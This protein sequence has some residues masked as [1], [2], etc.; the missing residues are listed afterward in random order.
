MKKSGLILA[1]ICLMLAI[2]GVFSANAQDKLSIS[3]SSE[4][5]EAGE[6]VTLTLSLSGNPGISYLSLVFDFDD[7]KLTFTGF[8]HDFSASDFPGVWA[9]NGTNIN[10]RGSDNCAYNG[11][12][13]KL[14]F[15]VAGNAASG[16]VPVTV[17]ADPDDDGVLQITDDEPDG[18]NVEAEYSA[19][20]V[21]IQATGPVLPSS[22]TLATDSAELEEGDTL[23]L[24]ATVLPEEA[25]D[26]TVKWESSDPSVATVE[27]GLVTA[28]A[29]GTATITATSNADD[30]VSAVCE[31]TV[32]EKEPTETLPTSVS[33]NQQSAE[34][35]EGDTLTLTATVLPEEAKDRTVKWESSDPSV[36]TVEDGVVRAVAPGTATITATSNVDDSL[37]ARCEVTVKEKNPD[38]EVLPQSISLDGTPPESLE[39]GGGTQVS[40]TIQPE[41]ANQNV[42]WESSDPN[43]A[44]VDGDGVI[45]AVGEGTVTIIGRAE[46]D[47]TVMVSFRI[48][49][50]PKESEP[51][52]NP[53]P[54]GGFIFWRIGNNN[55]LPHTGFSAGK[56]TV[57]PDM[58]KDLKYKELNWTLEI[59]AYS[60]MADIV[61][62]PYV[63]GEYPVTW[64]GEDVGLLEGS[65]L[66][67]KGTTVITGHNHLNDESFGPFMFLGALGEGERI[68]VRDP[69]NGLLVFKVYEN[70][71][72]RET[73]F[74]AV[75]EIASRYEGSLTMITCE[76]ERASGGYD[77]RRVVAARPI[78]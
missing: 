16:D 57:L 23:S 48:K 52:E 65:S 47:P 32:K 67:G 59:P 31:I 42:K 2:T 76:D 69:K 6:N 44:T 46:G 10:W 3:L 5:A 1:V 45:T 73:D 17:G 19:G 14:N 58:P 54:D 27:D 68:F 41:D 78:N 55:V 33:L 21:T 60:L 9:E 62:V 61:E 35:K 37:S 66:P 64:L 74:E 18:V 20:K 71:K 22:I 13:L 39:V 40:A 11:D 29:P 38:D 8:D 24:T 26:R 7:A 28:V 30:S 15:T 51:G 50:N 56:T 4:T 75:E 53:K 25:E 72:V 12:V 77:Y 70:Q 63:D 36:A 34:L 43:V 49:V